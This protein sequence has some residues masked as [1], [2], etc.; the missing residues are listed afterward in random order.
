[1]I[2]KK[3]QIKISYSRWKKRNTKKKKKNKN[4]IN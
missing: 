1:M 3:T 4:F 2:Q